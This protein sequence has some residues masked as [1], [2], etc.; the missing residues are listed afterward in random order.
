MDGEEIR[1]HIR[2]AAERLF[3]PGQVVELRVITKQGFI[4]SGYFDDVRLLADAAA[5]WDSDRQVE[6]IYWTLN[7]VNPDCLH[8]AKNKMRERVGKKQGTTSDREIAR[9]KLVLVDIDSANRPT[10]VS[11]TEAEVGFSKECALRVARFLHV[12]RGWGV[13]VVGMSGNGYHLLFRTD[14]PNDERSTEAVRKVLYV[15]SELFDTERTK[16]DTS[17]FNASR[18]SKVYGTMVRKGDDTPERP[19][20]RALMLKVTT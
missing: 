13:P 1:S 7:P 12:E 11:A 3:D 6:G 4:H 8:R 14:M 16:V 5:K 9:R 19:H 17:V 18:I 20:R 10:G 15:L 2:E